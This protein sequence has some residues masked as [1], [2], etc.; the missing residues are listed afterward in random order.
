M[1]I[2]EIAGIDLSEIPAD[3]HCKVISIGADVMDD[4]CASIGAVVIVNEL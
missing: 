4:R 3:L 1:M 2:T